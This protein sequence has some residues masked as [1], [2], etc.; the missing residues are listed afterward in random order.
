MIFFYF[1]C[2]FSFVFAN[3]S[4]K[5]LFSF[6][7]KDFYDIDLYQAVGKR[8]WD[9]YDLNKKRTVLNDFLKREIGF[10]EARSLGFHLS[11]NTFKK[12]YIRKKQL[13]INNAY[14]HLVARP[15]ISDYEVL[16]NNKNLSSSVSVWHLLIGFI[17]SENKSASELSKEESFELISFIKN[18]ILDSLNKGGVLEDVFSFYAKKFSHDPSAKQNGGFLGLVDWGQT[19]DSFQK[20]VFS[21]NKNSLSDILLTEYGYHLSFVDSFAYSDYYFYSQPYYDDLAYKVGMRSLSFDSLRQKSSVFDSTLLNDSDFFINFDFS[22]K[23]FDHIVL[24]KKKERLVSSKYSLIEWVESFNLSGFLVS[25]NKKL[26]GVNW[27][28]NKLSHIPSSRVPSFV[29]YQDFSLFLKSLV[30]EDLVLSL[31]KKKQIEKTISFERDFLDHSKN[32]VFGDFL[33]SLLNDVVIDSLAVVDKYNSGVFV[34]DYLNP[35][36]VVVSEIKFSSFDEAV[37][38]LD[39]INS[40]FS[41]DEALA[42]YNGKTREPFAF[43]FGGA[44]GEEAFSLLE[45]DVSKIINNPSKTFSIFRVDRFLKEEPFT[46]SLVYNQIERKLIKEKQDQIKTSLLQNMIKNNNIGVNYDILGL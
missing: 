6:N 37:I 39:K 45:G 2:L 15:L 30:L 21:L 41:F 16:N 35:K 34:G 14:E 46:L 8:A 12:L 36:R 43:G 22:E 1:F 29:N 5:P 42:L 27:F 32:I 24:K 28:L 19:V 10:L 20:P 17:N 44:V 13:L 7:N 9:G 40:G 3:Y 11:P 31:S 33:G 4:P 38:A 25:Y 18:S 23:L 26:F